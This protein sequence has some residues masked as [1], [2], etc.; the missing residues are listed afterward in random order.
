MPTKDETMQASILKALEL[1]KKDK[2]NAKPLFKSM[3]DISLWLAEK[4][5]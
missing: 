3:K 1:Y 4:V 5:K 2:E